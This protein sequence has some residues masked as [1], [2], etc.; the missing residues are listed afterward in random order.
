MARIPN[1]RRLRVLRPC[2]AWF[3]KEFNP[4]IVAYATRNPFTLIKITEGVF[5]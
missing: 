4:I 5:S 3:L 1:W 2:L